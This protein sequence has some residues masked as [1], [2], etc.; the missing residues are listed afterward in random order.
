MKFSPRFVIP[1]SV[2]IA[3][4]IS[5][6]IRAASN[7]GADS[8]R[9]AEIPKRMQ[10]FVDDG[11]IAG[12]VTLVARQGKTVSLEAVGLADLANRTPMRPNSLFWIASMTKPI[13]AVAVLMLQDAGKLSVDDPVEKHLPEFKGQWMIDTR[14]NDRMTL[15]K[16]PRPIT[17]RDLLTHTSGLSDVAAPRFDCSL[18]ELIMAYSQQPL[19][20]P[21][22]SRW[23]YSNPGINTLGRIVEV[24]SGQRFEQFLRQRIL[25]VLEMTDTT[26]WPS[27]EQVGRLAK[28]YKAAPNG[29][30]LEETPVS[31]IKGG[32]S[33]PKRTPFPA[34]GLFS[35]A[36]DIAHFY[37]MMLNGGEFKGAR[38]LSRLAVEQMTHPQTGGLKTGFVDGMSFGFGF[39]VVK[40]PLGVT[41]ML[42]PGTFG[43]GGA[44]ATQSWAD[45]KKDAIL[46][47]M[48]QRAGFPNGDN[49][50]VRR[51]FQEAAVAAMRE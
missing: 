25:G 26:F 47:L 4:F 19:R 23:E 7:P 39:A 20:F 33:D 10:A 22:G 6:G 41:A 16:P 30:G 13:T 49:S 48:I 42:S 46:V 1:C 44:Y 11:T 5:G 38:L 32:L 14:T 29:P 2:L 27:P 34:G 15:V 21:P 43:H 9:L 36:S 51:A 35:T 50:P 8:T 31:F 18:A 3:V 17:L 37:Q 28:S 45:P 12:A 40:E 24:V